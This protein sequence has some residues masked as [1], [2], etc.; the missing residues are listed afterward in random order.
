ML[1]HGDERGGAAGGGR[2]RS[3]WGSSGFRQEGEHGCAETASHAPLVCVGRSLLVRVAPV[4]VRTR[5]LGRGGLVWHALCFAAY[6][7]G[8]LAPCTRR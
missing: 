3:P 7:R 6:Q 5:G 8:L 4:R 2:Q 1:E